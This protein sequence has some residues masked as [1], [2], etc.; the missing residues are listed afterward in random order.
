[1]VTLSPCGSRDAR[2][3]RPRP[4]CSRRR[5]ASPLGRN[6]HRIPVAARPTGAICRAA[7]SLDLDQASRPRR[8]KACP[9]V[10]AQ[11]HSAMNSS[12]RPRQL[13][14]ACCFVPCL[15]LSLLLP[16]SGWALEIR[17]VQTCSGVVLRLRGEI[18]DGD[19]SRLKSHFRAKEAIVG[20]DLS[21]DGGV[22]EEGLRIAD[23]TRRKRF[24]VYVAGECNSACVDIFFAA[25]KRYFAAAS[26]IGVHA[27]S[28][29]RDVEDAASRL[30]T[31]RM[32]RLWSE[33]GVPNSA[34]GKMVAT[35]PETITYLDRADLSGIDA[36]EGNPFACK[37]ERSSEAGPE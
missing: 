34:I 24:T 32:A 18:K 7:S 3:D 29:H 36:S 9:A 5:S 13:G 25:G 37:V 21:S 15:L 33:Q 12:S 30:L 6:Q 16:L 10:I 14:R 23:F 2:T 22:F 28:N 27:I 19:L 35:R 20:F 1:M 4:R 11:G 26:K 31:I 17:R 8:S